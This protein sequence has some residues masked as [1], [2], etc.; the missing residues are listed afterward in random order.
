MAPKRAKSCQLA[1][2][3]LIGPVKGVGHQSEIATLPLE[4][5]VGWFP[6]WGSVFDTDN[7]DVLRLL[8]V[9]EKD[10]T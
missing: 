8:I 6:M 4:R 5:N 3:A 9:E 1:S 7:Q 2:A 10:L